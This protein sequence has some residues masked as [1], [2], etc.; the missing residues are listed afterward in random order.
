MIRALWQHRRLLGE[1]I[2]R[3]LAERYRGSLLGVFW[4]FLSPLAFLLVF[5][6][7]FT[8][9]FQA[10]FGMEPG[11]GR[12]QFAL[13]LMAG[14]IM[15][16]FFSECTIRA[17]RVIVENANYVKKVVFPLELLPAVT[18]GAA[19]INLVVG[20]GILLAGSLVAYQRVPATALLMPLLLA[21]LALFV[22]G[23]AW[24]LSSLGVFLRDVGQMI[25][26]LVQMML[27]LSPV[28]YPADSLPESAQAVMALNP[29]AFFIE[30]GRSL[31]LEGQTPAPTSWL[32]YL[33]VSLATMWA[34]GYWFK[35]TRHGFADVL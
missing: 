18:V 31:W 35:R 12:L 17:P 6:F 21:P 33:L 2:R 9:V 28:F 7:V 19:L 16:N 1:L 11:G 10:R 32:T 27:F 25:A 20:L 3:E 4:A 22:L 15:Y 30:S 8:T 23:L 26:P 5:T 13:F 14:L 24:F 34:G 29:L